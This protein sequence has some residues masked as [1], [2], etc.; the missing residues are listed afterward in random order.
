M[1]TIMKVAGTR[2]RE[3]DSMEACNS[4]MEH[5]WEMV[6]ADILDLPIKLHL[7]IN[8]L[9]PIRHGKGEVGTHGPIRLAPAG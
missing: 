4:I 5:G 9:L 1:F 7:G 2:I 3:M 8:S 6:E